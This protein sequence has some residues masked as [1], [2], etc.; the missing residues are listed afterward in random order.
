MR[1]ILLALVLLVLAAADLSASTR[2]CNGTLVTQGVCRNIANQ[3]L[4]YD[5]P[6]T[7]AVD[8]RDAISAGFQIK[9]SGNAYLPFV[10]CTATRTFALL[11]NGQPSRIL[12]TAGVIPD[13]C[14]LGATNVANP[15]TTSE[16]SDA[17]VDASFRNVVIEWKHQ[18]AVEAVADPNTIPTPDTGA[19]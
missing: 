18:V 5:A 14:I 16:F 2:L 1:R 10:Q 12:A 15:Q 8:L 7:S 11:L 4:Y 9:S 17:E 3:L 19:P 6:T 13:V